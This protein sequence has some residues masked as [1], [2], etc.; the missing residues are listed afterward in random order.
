MIAERYAITIC[1]VDKDKE[2]A[3]E[4]AKKLNTRKTLI[5]IPPCCVKTDEDITSLYLSHLLNIKKS[6]AILI[7]NA[8]VEIPESLNIDIEYA[9]RNNTKVFY[10]YNPEDSWKEMPSKF[11]V[12]EALSIITDALSHGFEFKVKNNKIYFRKI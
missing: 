8:D 7:I 3:M 11:T 2:L 6:D 1:A 4:F 5:F 10:A 9:I 12:S